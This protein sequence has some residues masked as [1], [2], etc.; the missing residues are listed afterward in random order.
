LIL[1][2]PEQWKLSRQLKLAGDAGA[3]SINWEADT[4]TSDLFPSCLSLLVVSPAHNVTF[5]SVG[6][7]LNSIYLFGCA[8]TKPLPGCKPRPK[9]PQRQCPSRAGCSAGIDAGA[10]AEA[11][12]AARHGVR[13]AAKLDSEM[14]RFSFSLFFTPDHDDIGDGG[15]VPP[16]AKL[17][18]DDHLPSNV[19]PFF[20]HFL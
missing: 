10:L 12:P 1:S 16:D 11:V 5:I 19:P 9:P 6:A 2:V 14:L 8:L 4:K 20:L 18:F 15:M 13:C 17:A 3:V 7:V